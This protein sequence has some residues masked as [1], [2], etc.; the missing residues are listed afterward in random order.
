MVASLP[1]QDALTSRPLAHTSR[2]ISADTG[3]PIHFRPSFSRHLPDSLATGAICI[4]EC[5]TSHPG[6]ALILFT[7][8]GRLNDGREASRFL[9][10][11][12]HWAGDG[13]LP[14][15][16]IRNR[17]IQ[18]GLASLEQGKKCVVFSQRSWWPIL[19]AQPY[20]G[21]LLR[22]IEADILGRVKSAACGMR[23]AVLRA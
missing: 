4:H 6:I 3:Q 12:T 16:G 17:R 22:S 13:A 14:K 1:Q 9:Y 2:A 21:T 7:T 23:R 15:S 20:R 5:P 11:E 18:A 19:H 8:N 10:S